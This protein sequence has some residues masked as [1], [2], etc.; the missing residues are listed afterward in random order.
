MYL[1][2]G[3][4]SVDYFVRSLRTSRHF[5]EQKTKDPKTS[6][7]HYSFGPWDC[8]EAGEHPPNIKIRAKIKPDAIT[9]SLLQY[10]STDHH[11]IVEDEV[12]G[13]SASTSLHK[14]SRKRSN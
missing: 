4:L 14:K 12:Q 7:P 13:L 6:S 3:C 10:S 5:D 9:V 2:R 1:Q 11:L 8:R